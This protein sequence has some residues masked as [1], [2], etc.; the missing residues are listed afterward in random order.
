MLEP[1]QVIHQ[2]LEEPE[3]RRMIAYLDRIIS[4]QTELTHCQPGFIYKGLTYR[5]SSIPRGKIEY[6]GLH[7]L[8]YDQMDSFL[9]DQLATREEIKRISQILLPLIRPCR[10]LQDLRDALPE[11]LVTSFTNISGLPRTRPVAWCLDPESRHWRQFHN[12]LPIIETYAAAR[13][14][15]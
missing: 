9:Q 11:C 13:F 3:K 7:S 10:D 1:V 12:A 5:H 2:V 4:K 6:V 14:L 8:L 15:Y